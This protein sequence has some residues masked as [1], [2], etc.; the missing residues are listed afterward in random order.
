LQITT[1]TKHRGKGDAEDEQLHVLPLYL[2]ES[3][4]ADIKKKIELGAVE[5]R[6]WE[7]YRLQLLL[8]S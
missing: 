8:L 3:T 4:E 5:V 6:Y 1:L 2:L 7:C